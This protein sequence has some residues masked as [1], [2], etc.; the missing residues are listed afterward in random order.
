M[1]IIS[2]ESILQKVAEK[3]YLPAN[4]LM[5]DLIKKHKGKFKIAFSISGIAMEQFR[6]YAPEVLDSF[7]KLGRYRTG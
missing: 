2:N 1:M 4:E 6:L 3:C 7:K 5:L